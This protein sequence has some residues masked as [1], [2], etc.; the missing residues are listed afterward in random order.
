M[1]ISMTL[2]SRAL[3]VVLA[4]RRIV[5]SLFVGFVLIVG[6]LGFAGVRLRATGEREVERD[7][8]SGAIGVCGDDVGK[9]TGEP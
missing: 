3:T 8:C 5:P 4:V 6:V 9:L 7:G 2:A 1:R